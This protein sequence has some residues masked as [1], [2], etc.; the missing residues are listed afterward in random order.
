MQPKDI[1]LKCM[2][3]VKNNGFDDDEITLSGLTALKASKVNAPMI[4]ECFLNLECELAWEKDL[5]E[6][7]IVFKDRKCLDG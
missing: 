2:E 4:K 3:T 5:S 1:F 6:E 7:G